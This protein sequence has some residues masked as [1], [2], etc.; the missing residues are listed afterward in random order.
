MVP[1]P[2]RRS[3]ATPC[4]RLFNE[5]R[6][7]PAGLVGTLDALLENATYPAPRPEANRPMDPNIGT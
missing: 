7:A 1:V 6:C 2:D 3:L 4:G 5:L